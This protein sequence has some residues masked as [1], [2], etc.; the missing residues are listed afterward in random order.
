MR[1]TFLVL[2]AAMMNGAAQLCAASSYCTASSRG[3][4]RP[5]EARRQRKGI[6]HHPQQRWIGHDAPIVALRL[7]AVPPEKPPCIARIRP[8]TAGPAL[9]KRSVTGA[10]EHHHAQIERDRIE[11]EENTIRDPAAFAAA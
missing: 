10:L 3:L 7:A 4:L 1:W 11:T 9:P 2:I 5:F 8:L 6:A